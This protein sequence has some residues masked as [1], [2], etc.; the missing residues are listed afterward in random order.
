MN[1]FK[2]R[3]F[4]SPCVKDILERRKQ[5]DENNG[6]NAGKMEKNL[7]KIQKGMEHLKRINALGK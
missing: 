7:E 4:N 1:Q 6:E 2:T 5:N 3:L